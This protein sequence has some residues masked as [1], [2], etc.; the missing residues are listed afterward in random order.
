[1]NVPITVEVLRPLQKGNP[2]LQ[3]LSNTENNAEN[4]L[5]K[6][7]TIC[8]FISNSLVWFNSISTT[9]GYLMLNPVFTYISN[10]ICKHTL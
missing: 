5:I 10:M 2:P 6:E 4:V 8:Y 9:V 7:D 3:M 1:M